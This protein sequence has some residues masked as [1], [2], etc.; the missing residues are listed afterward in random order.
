MKYLKEKDL[1]K[2]KNFSKSEY[3]FFVYHSLLKNRSLDLKIR[4]YL[5]MKKK[6]Y[7]YKVKKNSIKNRCNFSY[8]SRSVSRLFHLSRFSIRKFCFNGQVNGFFKAGW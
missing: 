1:K 5:Y 8:T 7:L 3:N 2:R 6:K 4:Q